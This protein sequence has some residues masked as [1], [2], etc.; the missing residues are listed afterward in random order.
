LK[1]LTAEIVEASDKIAAAEKKLKDVEAAPELKALADTHPRVA[2]AAREETAKLHAGDAENLVLWKQFIP[3]CLEALA[4]M[5]TRLGVHFDLTLGESYYQPFLGN[6]VESLLAR[7]IA[8]ISDG[9]ACVF[10]PGVEAPFIVRKTDGAYTY[11]TTDL[12]TIRYRAEKLS[13]D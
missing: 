3:A 10:I 13:A 2:A 6:V 1:R 4:T 12:A 7:Q 9:A 5:Y 8:V 11:A